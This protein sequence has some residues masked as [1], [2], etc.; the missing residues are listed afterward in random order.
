MGLFDGRKVAALERLAEAIERYSVV[1]ERLVELTE[2]NLALSRETLHAMQ[3]AHG[4]EPTVP[5]SPPVAPSGVDRLVV[6]RLLSEEDR[7]DLL[8]TR[9]PPVRSDVEPLRLPKGPSRFPGKEFFTFDE[10]MMV[11][12]IDENRLKRLVS[13]GEIRAFREGDQMKFKRTEILTLAGK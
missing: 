1:A 3:K 8:V 13:E 7:K 11:L 9:I 2:E 10:C 6:E 4:I 5:V 12:N